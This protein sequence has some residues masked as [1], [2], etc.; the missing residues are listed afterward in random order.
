MSSKYLKIHKSS[1]NLTSHSSVYHHYWKPVSA[2]PPN[3]VFVEPQQGE[4]DSSIL[5]LLI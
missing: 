3:G 4:D 5:G 2:V 1:D